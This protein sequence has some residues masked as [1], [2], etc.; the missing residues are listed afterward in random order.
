MEKG[1]GM[2]LDTEDHIEETFAKWVE[3]WESGHGTMTSPEIEVAKQFFLNGCASMQE[4]IR[5]ILSGEMP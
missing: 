4:D 2:N 1:T 3:I 5:A